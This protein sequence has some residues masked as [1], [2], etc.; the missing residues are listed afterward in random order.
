MN[1][2]PAAK[3]DFFYTETTMENQARGAITMALCDITLTD[4]FSLRELRHYSDGQENLAKDSNVTFLNVQNS[5]KK[6]K[7]ASFSEKTIGGKKEVVEFNFC[8]EV[9][10]PAQT[11]AKNKS[12][13]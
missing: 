1:V 3:T 7:E 10:A 5:L 11:K 4:L 9:S 13:F 12:T 8:Q 2:Y 6:K